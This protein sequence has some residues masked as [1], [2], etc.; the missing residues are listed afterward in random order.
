M[1]VTGQFGKSIT[2]S[3]SLA[4]AIQGIASE[5]MNLRMDRIYTAYINKDMFE[6]R[7]ITA[8]VANELLG[9]MLKTTAKGGKMQGDIEEMSR[10][11]RKSQ[12]IRTLNDI[13][14]TLIDRGGLGDYANKVRVI[15]EM[16][17]D[18]RLNP[19]EITNLKEELTKA[20]DAMLA[21]TL[22]QYDAGGKVTINGREIDLT[23]AGAK[24]QVLALYNSA[25]TST[26]EMADKLTRARDEAMASLAV[27]D[28]GRAYSAKT[29]TTDSD[30][31]AGKEEQL[32][33]LKSALEA[34]E[35]TGSA[36][37]EIAANLRTS[38]QNVTD[39][40]KS[41]TDAINTTGAQNRYDTTRESIF[42]NIDALEAAMRK[43]TALDSA[44]GQNSLQAVLGGDPNYA[45]YLI[46]EMRAA[47][48]GSSLTL[49]TGLNVQLTADGLYDLMM[50]TKSDAKSAYLWSRSNSYIDKTGKDN[51][52]SW[53]AA[54]Q[55]LVADAPNMR[56][57]DKYDTIT[58]GL[59]TKLNDAV[60]SVSNRV[61]ALKAAGD[62]LM[63]LANTPGIGASERAQLLN[64]AK[65]Y[66]TGTYNPEVQTYGD[67][68]GNFPLNSTTN[69]AAFSFGSAINPI[70]SGDSPNF[71]DAI[72][73]VYQ[74]S[75]VWNAGGGIVYTDTQGNT[76]AT[77]NV[78]ASPSFENGG[79]ISLL[80]SAEFNIGG[81]NLSR[82]VENV[83]QRIRVVRAGSGGATAD[84]DKNTIGWIAQGAN[85]EWIVT[86]V[87]N[88][89]EYIMK[90]ADAAN[91][92]ETQF[93]GNPAATQRII[94][95]QLVSTANATVASAWLDTDQ[96]DGFSALELMDG[97]IYTKL[98]SA[99]YTLEADLTATIKK[100][101]D[102]AIASGTI[103]VYADGSVRVAGGA[104]DGR[105]LDITGQFGA[106]GG[107]YIKANAAGM[108]QPGWGVE[109]YV[110][111]GTKPGEVPPPTTPG[112][113]P[114][115][116]NEALP[117][118]VGT[119]D[120]D[121]ASP[122]PMDSK[123]A[124]PVNPMSQKY[125]NA[126]PPVQPG[127]RGGRDLGR[128]TTFNP[129]TR[130]T[131]AGAARVGTG[132]IGSTGASTGQFNAGVG[133]GMLDRFMRNVPSATSTTANG[134]AP[135]KRT[136]R[137]P[138]RRSI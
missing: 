101:I 6:G 28:A 26:P 2:G 11:I 25:I 75:A 31:R 108:S 127:V 21:N 48:G 65:L 16:L 63:T 43:F 110:A 19:D 98:T 89:K 128:G 97:S 102:A 56:V 7:E 27:A 69:G 67:A 44:L 91:L 105:S 84:L 114:G 57:E 109:D 115:W 103:R 38:I 119:P 111:P 10:Q 70:I 85:G 82:Q 80:T 86:K 113:G 45:N 81:A 55:N 71:V 100:S 15:K 58:E 118:D 136:Y 107:A 123:Y 76:V 18:P 39:D 32:A 83:V 1:A 104:K 95:G 41:Y 37:S 88:G 33:I 5:Y 87:V 96:G 131:G 120:P 47:T 29:R 35:R 135:T 14:G 122:H 53:W 116:N 66:L 51:I 24:D 125:A 117:P 74:D 13:D 138:A 137:D 59:V 124:T 130:G 94:G 121:P 126:K 34:I 68:S 106:I 134:T 52:A 12:R 20:T 50:D 112:S 42:G 92:I 73:S 132:P 46:D 77:T 78:G 61:A 133:S 64:E 30:K 17:L 8:A 54:A 49:S 79:G 93:G 22:N 3:G 60:G 36:Q 72:T 40:V 62:A 90:A 9:K 4:S 23:G 129:E 99:G